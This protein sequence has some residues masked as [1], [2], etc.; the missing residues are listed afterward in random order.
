MNEVTSQKKKEG[1]KIQNRKKKSLGK[2][3]TEKKY[4]KQ[5]VHA[6]VT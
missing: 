1:A 4:S 5:L 3:N 6:K 2:K